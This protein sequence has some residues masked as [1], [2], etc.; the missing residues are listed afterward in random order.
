MVALLDAGRVMLRHWQR[1]IDLPVQL[2]IAD[3]AMF[4]CAGRE[5]RQHGRSDP[6][7]KK[8]TYRHGEVLPKNAVLLL[9][10]IQEA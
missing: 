6:S 3:E 1:C 2:V 8:I 7:G 5:S 10:S 9:R 4:G